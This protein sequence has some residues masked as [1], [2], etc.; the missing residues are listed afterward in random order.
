MDTIELMGLHTKIF[1]LN[2]K[3]NKDPSSIKLK[4]DIQ[5]LKDL[6]T[7]NNSK[8]PRTKY[9]TS[10]NAK[11]SNLMFKKPWSRLN[12]QL[13]SDRL[14]VFCMNLNLSQTNKKN[15]YKILKRDLENKILSKKKEVVYDLEDTQIK[16]I[17]R[18]KSYLDE[19]NIDHI[20]VF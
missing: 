8:Y 11:A 4:K 5:I 12:S 1:S 15:L 18:L 20:D 16:E 6:I 7:K 17:P 9:K 10:I 13:K 14:F 19:L 2:Y 3:L